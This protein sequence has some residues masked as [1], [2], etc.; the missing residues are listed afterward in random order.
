MDREWTIRPGS[1]KA[2][3]S[4]LNELYQIN[5]TY[6]RFIEMEKEKD[7]ISLPSL[8]RILKGGGTSLLKNISKGFDFFEENLKK[9]SVDGVNGI[10]KNYELHAEAF[11]KKGHYIEDWNDSFTLKKTIGIDVKGKLNYFDL[12]FRYNPIGVSKQLERI[13]FFLKKQKKPG[14]NG[15]SVYNNINIESAENI[16]LKGYQ[17][18]PNTPEEIDYFKETVDDLIT[19]PKKKKKK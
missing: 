8:E 10:P 9:Y 4:D 1:I 18:F 17:T 13:G 2:T 16:D 15:K 12:S 6:N 5:E 3:I 19:K 7:R 11:E 14:K